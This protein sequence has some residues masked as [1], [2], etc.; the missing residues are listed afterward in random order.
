ML[1]NTLLT[2]HHARQW[3]ADW[4]T[5]RNTGLL[6]QAFIDCYGELD[7][8][9][10]HYNNL[11][12]LGSLVLIYCTFCELKNTSLDHIWRAQMCAPNT[13][14]CIFGNI[15]HIWEVE[16]CTFAPCSTYGY[17]FQWQVA[18]T[19]RMLLRTTDLQANLVILNLQHPIGYQPLVQAQESDF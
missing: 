5:N 17:F 12:V 11:K 15:W 3:E 9:S 8:V 13:I 16:E 7:N 14:F 4:H 10:M 6:L 19:L 2:A 18:S 1:T